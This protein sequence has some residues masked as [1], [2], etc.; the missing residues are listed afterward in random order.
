MIAVKAKAELESFKKLQEENEKIKK[1]L[2]VKKEEVEN[3]REAETELMN[4]REKTR[5]KHLEEIAKAEEEKLE[6]AKKINELEQ[7]IQALLKRSFIFIMLHT[8]TCLN[9]NCYL[10]LTS[11]YQELT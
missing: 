7:E 2:G 5:I 9:R 8:M 10:N 1:Q 4:N 3:H 11:K 6:K